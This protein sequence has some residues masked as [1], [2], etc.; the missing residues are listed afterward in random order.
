MCD[1]CRITEIPFKGTYVLTGTT[2]EPDEE[3]AVGGGPHHATPPMADRPVAEDVRDRRTAARRGGRQLLQ[4]A[5]GAAGTAIVAGLGANAAGLVTN[6][7]GQLLQQGVGGGVGGLAGAVGGGLAAAVGHGGNR[8]QVTM[9]VTR[10]DKVLDD[11]VTV[12]LVPKNCVPD[13]G[14]VH[15]LRPCAG[16]GYR[17]Y[18][19]AGQAY[20]HHQTHDDDGDE[21][22]EPLRPPPHDVAADIVSQVDGLVREMIGSRTTPVV[23]TPAGHGHRYRVTAAAAAG[24][25]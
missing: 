4:T 21:R 9:Y 17:P 13:A 1:V 19:A 22:E 25:F 3:H 18:A 15:A 20:H 2:A 10:V 5:L 7:G 24:P 14:Q 16:A 8:N 6:A 12:T 11:R 23:G